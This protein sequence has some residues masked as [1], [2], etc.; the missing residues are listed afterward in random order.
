MRRLLSAVVLALASLSLSPAQAGGLLQDLFAAAPRTAPTVMYYAPAQP[1]IRFLHD[2][3]FRVSRRP[4]TQRKAIVK[5]H[6][7]K[8]WV[9]GRKRAIVHVAPTARWPR[10][11]HTRRAP[12]AHA[13]KHRP[14]FAR[15]IVTPS[16]PA[17]QASPAVAK[18]DPP[19][20]I[21]NDPTLRVGDAYMT[22]EGLRIY[23]G[24]QWKAKERKVFVDFR[25]SGLGEGAKSRLAA[26]D[27]AMRGAISH[28]VAPLRLKATPAGASTRKSVDRQGRVIRVVGP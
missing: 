13:I 5:K 28:R 6:Q 20:H 2:E 24:P 8:R 7:S 1:Q 21:D 11:E 3:G 22:P 25:R 9:A 26:L 16:A 4:S 27:G 19:A 14:K 17:P 12:R 23:R 10:A 15:A 18:V